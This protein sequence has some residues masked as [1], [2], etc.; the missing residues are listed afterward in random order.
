VLFM[1]RQALRVKAVRR[2]FG[3]GGHWF[4]KLPG[5]MTDKDEWRGW[6][7]GRQE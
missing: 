7:A 3:P 2:G 6:I 1:A 4:W 5:H